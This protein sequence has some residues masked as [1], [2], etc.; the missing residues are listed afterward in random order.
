LSQVTL[1]LG[2]AR[3]G[4]SSFAEKLALKRAGENGVLYVATAEPLDAEMQ[5]RVIQHRAARPASWRTL[6]TAYNLA[7]DIKANWQT[8]QLAL[9]DCLTVW[10]S[11]LL[12]R[13]CE[14]SPTDPDDIILPDMVKLEKSIIAELT[15][16]IE[17]C[18]QKQRGLIMVSNEVGMGLVPPYPMGRAY[19][20]MLGRVNQRLAQEA[21]EVFMVLAGLPVN[22]KALSEAFP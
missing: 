10:T 18:R 11:N 14:F 21:D 1:I 15:N 7:A 5:E 17:D 8:E 3:S 13:E 19:R 9:I 20:D 12:L 2:G 4:K 22:W 6:E 16:L